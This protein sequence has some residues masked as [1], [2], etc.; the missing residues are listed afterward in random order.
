MKHIPCLIL[1]ITVFTVGF[2]NIVHAQES[3]ISNTT[4][5]NISTPLNTINNSPNGT[6][7]LSNFSASSPSNATP[8]PAQ[9]E[10]FMNQTPTT[11][12]KKNSTNLSP[13]TPQPESPLQIEPKPAPEAPLYSFD[14]QKI[15]PSDVRIGDS[16]INILISNTGNQ[17]LVNLNAVITGDGVSVYNQ[18]SIPFLAPGDSKWLLAWI[19]TKKVGKIPLDVRLQDRTFRVNL[20]V[21]DTEQHTLA[22]QAAEEAAAHRRKVREIQD[23]LS[24]LSDSYEAFQRDFIFKETKGYVLTS[25]NLQDAKSYLRTAQSSLAKDDL[26]DAAANLVLLR[27]ELSDVQEKLRGAQPK[28]RTWKD[29][30]K[31]N[32]ALLSG[33]V[34]VLVGGLAVY[35]KFKSKREDL[36]KNGGWFG[37]KKQPSTEDEEQIEE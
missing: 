37:K 8:T 18:E 1:F 31:E 35:E 32:V 26:S 16:Q 34:G 7:N 21:I 14:A 24:N 4:T 2:L 28:P 5:S 19:N 22:K 27:A 13:S 12:P 9:P 10:T 23:E 17:I 29:P 11:S 6:S 3:N 25:V 15:I 30:V 20:N 33:I 36:K